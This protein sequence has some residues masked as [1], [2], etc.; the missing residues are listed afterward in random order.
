MQ[1]EHEQVLARVESI[2]GMLAARVDKLEQELLEVRKDQMVDASL[3][4]TIDKAV[5]DAGPVGPSLGP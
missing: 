2:L 3:G 4:G 1:P 5:E